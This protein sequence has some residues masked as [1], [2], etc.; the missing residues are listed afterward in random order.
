MS[1]REA[2][3]PN[4]RR[5]RIQRGVSLQQIATET[6]VSDVLWAAM[7]K[8][9]FS[10]W[11]NGIFARAYI[12]DYAKIIG[13]DPDTTVDEFCRWFP[14][15]DRRAD[16][17]ILEH[18]ELLDHKPNLKNEVPASV[19]EDRRWSADKALQEAAERAATKPAAS[20]PGVFGRLRRALGRA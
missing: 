6:N 4:L 14:Q 7:E 16:R 19:G 8:N 2:F 1:G 13:V 17:Q 20:Q 5:V 18:A 9:D 11:P 12:R 3:G 15:G 10:R